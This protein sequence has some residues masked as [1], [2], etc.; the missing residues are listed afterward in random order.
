M[1]ALMDGWRSTYVTTE[2]LIGQY[3]VLLH[4]QR[5]NKGAGSELTQKRGD[6]LGN[7]RGTRKVRGSS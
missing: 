3:W 2:H 4:L 6:Q 7:G 5:R 1:A